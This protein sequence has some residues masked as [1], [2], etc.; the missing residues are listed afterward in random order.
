MKS[1]PTTQ[2]TPSDFWETA[3]RHKKKLLVF[4]TLIL[5]I[6]TAVILWFPRT[7]QSEAKLFLQVG[8][9]SV[10]IDPIATTGSTISLQKT[11]RE[12]E[13]RSAMQVIGSRG[14]LAEVVKE[15]GAEYI[16]RGGPAGADAG[17]S[18]IAQKLF[19][20]IVGLIKTLKQID[21]V[22]IEE[23]ALIELE[24]SLIVD[25]ERDST[26]I[27]LQYDAKSPAGAQAV[28]AKLVEVY[29]REHLRIHR[30]PDSEQFFA[31]Q[32]EMLQKR[33]DLA[34]NNLRDAKNM[35][36]LASV[37]GRRATLEDQLKLV[38]QNA[39]STEQDLATSL[40]RV[41]DLKKQIAAMPERMIATRRS[42]P[43]EGADLLREQLYALQMRQMDLKARYS[44][45]HPMVLAISAQLEEAEKVVE[46][47]SENREETTDD[48]NPNRRQLSLELLQQ[49]SIVAGHEARLDTLQ[50]QKKLVHQDLK[51]I[52]R[53]EVMLDELEREVTLARTKFFKY[54]ENR[55]QA[56]IDQALQD[57]KISSVSIPQVATLAEKPVSPSKVLVGLGALVL[58]FGG[59]LSWVAA[60]EQL[61]DK[62]RS[63]EDVEEHLKLPVFAEIPK[64]D[65]HGRVLNY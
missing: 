53:D 55:E 23:E 7:Y 45:S 32:Y 15:L 31:G 62:I 9:E 10:G 46:D 1:R 36:G 56:R 2:L 4:P 30:N 8:R 51:Q 37:E 6:A 20:P 58:A 44:D 39:Y 16:L 25:S 17:E 19:S 3:F 26:V 42:I 35:M 13:V 61:N 27:V 47:Q 33:L 12:T 29:Q 43:N 49:S 64:S 50:E 48:I 21:P 40:A 5:A 65:I 22:S 14:V 24:E 57:Q 63:G 54:A 52:N 59:T 28:L 18:A 11:D 34:N 38:E 41:S 60:S